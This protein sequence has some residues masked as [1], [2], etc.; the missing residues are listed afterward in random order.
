MGMA[1]VFAIVNVV[2]EHLD[3]ANAKRRD[4]IVAQREAAKDEEQRL[5]MVRECLEFM[6][7]HV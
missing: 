2:K 7:E 4:E 5:E 1:M 6:L 3:D